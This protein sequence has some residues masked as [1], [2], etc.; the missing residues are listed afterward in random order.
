ML[1]RAFFGGSYIFKWLVFTLILNVLHL[2]LVLFIQKVS[3][4]VKCNLCKLKILLVHFNSS[5]A[6]NA[7]LLTEKQ[8]EFISLASIACFG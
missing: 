2:L 1:N 7:Y 5:I 4:S 8:G 6:L 3:H